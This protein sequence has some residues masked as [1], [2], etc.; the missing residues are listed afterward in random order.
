MEDQLDE[1]ASGKLSR[2]Q[3][4]TDFYDSFEKELNLAQ[5]NIVKMNIDRPTEEICEKC[6][7]PMVIKTGRFGEFLACSGFPRCRNTRKIVREVGVLCPECG[8][9]IIEKK[10]RRGQI[11]YGCANYPRCR[12]ASWY[13]PLVEKCPACGGLLVEKKQ[14]KELLKEC[15]KCKMQLRSDVVND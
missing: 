2:I 8:G 11:F 9:Q 5:E 4:L 1:V 7:Q 6:G 15:L 10:S 13:K 3:L 12:F 14:R